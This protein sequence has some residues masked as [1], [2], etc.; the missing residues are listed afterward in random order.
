MDVWKRKLDSE[1]VKLLFWFRS[2]VEFGNMSVRQ[3]PES[4]DR[5]ACCLQLVSSIFCRETG[6]KFEYK[7]Q[8]LEYIETKSESKPNAITCNT[9]FIVLYYDEFFFGGLNFE[10]SVDWIF[11]GL[12][13]GWWYKSRW[14]HNR[15]WPFILMDHIC[16]EFSQLKS[17]NFRND[18]FVSI[19]YF[20]NVM[21]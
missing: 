12:K 13:R 20:F 16:T 1:D 17:V 11:R 7:N 2:C 5:L 8:A 14:S 15:K 6:C 4:K 3:V 10:L 9:Y 19:R 21:K 18:F